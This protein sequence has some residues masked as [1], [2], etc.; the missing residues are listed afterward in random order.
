MLVERYVSDVVDA[1]AR[2]LY[3]VVRVGPCPWCGRGDVHAHRIG[4]AG[5]DR[6][7]DRRAQELSEI[8]LAPA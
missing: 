4:G 1:G 5:D 7:V 3:A 6:D 8:G 2:D